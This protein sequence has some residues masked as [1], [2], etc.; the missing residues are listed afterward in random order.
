MSRIIPCLLVDNKALYKTVNFKNPRY[1]GDPFNTIKLFNGK[2]VDEIIVLDIG[3]SRD[4]KHPDFD[5][6]KKLASEC[7][8]PIC[9]GGG[10]STIEDVE[11]VFR[12]GIDKVSFNT[13]LHNNIPLVK[14]AIKRYGSQSIVASIDFKKVGSNYFVFIN[15]GRTNT[16]V[17]LSD[18][19]LQL[20]KIGVGELLLTSIDNEGTYKGYIQVIFEICKKTNIPVTANGGASSLTEMLLALKLGASAASAGSLFSFKGKRRAVIVNYP[21]RDEVNKIQQ[22]VGEIF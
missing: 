15:N 19:A 4:K 1:L 10:L 16:N 20:E 13:A 6:I 11:K 18:F 8:M 21:S 5:F 7:F 2:E 12:L 3:A 22:E 9:Y 17:K 14:E